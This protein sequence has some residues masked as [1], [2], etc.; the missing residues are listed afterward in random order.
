MLEILLVVTIIGILASVVVLSATDV[1]RQRTIRAE[2]E[3]LALAVELAR[4]EARLRN[5]VWG[6]V[7][8][9]GS[10]RFQRYDEAG[11]RWQDVERREFGAD[12]TEDGIEFSAGPA[13]TGPA[14]GESDFPGATPAGVQG[15]GGDGIAN[16]VAVS[17]HGERPPDVVIY[18]G[19]ELTPF[20]VVVTG[21]DA[22]AAWV[23]QSDG[24]QRTRAAVETEVVDTR[25]DL[26]QWLLDTGLVQ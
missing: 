6:L 22:Y 19:G 5:E 16:A 23:A 14:G 11:D 9:G 1:G 17:D 18:P 21:G 10:Y 8:D 3:R 7:V 13:Q 26:D 24:I 20:E 4:D 2:A 12:A 15:R 25:D